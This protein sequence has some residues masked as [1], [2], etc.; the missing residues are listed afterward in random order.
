MIR[1]SD[2]RL[3]WRL[4]TVRG[5]VAWENAGEDLST[6]SFERCRSGV[7]VVQRHSACTAGHDY[8]GLVNRG[9]GSGTRVLWVTQ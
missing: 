9:G 7:M 6:G 3:W 1:C 2:H 5:V 8:G 4:T